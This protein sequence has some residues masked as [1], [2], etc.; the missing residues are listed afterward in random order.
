MPSRAAKCADLSRLCISNMFS[1]YMYVERPAPSSQLCPP[2]GTR[3]GCDSSVCSHSTI[4]SRFQILIFILNACPAFFLQPD[5]VAQAP[6]GYG[7]RNTKSKADPPYLGVQRSEAD[8]STYQTVLDSV[9]TIDGSQG[10]FITQGLPTALQAAR[11]YDC[12][13]IAIIGPEFVTVGSNV[14]FHPYS[15]KDQVRHGWHIAA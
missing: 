3:L 1:L 4:C 7:T 11:L 5:V 15:Y 10:S 6:P 12:A 9:P 14:N 8:L 2:Q 13:V